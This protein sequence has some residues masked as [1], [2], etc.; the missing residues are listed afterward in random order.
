MKTTMYMLLTLLPL[1]ILSNYFFLIHLNLG[2]MGASYHLLAMGF[3]ISSVYTLYLIFG[4]PFVRN[5]WCGWSRQAWRGWGEFL[6]LGQFW[7]T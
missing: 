2:T 1:G 4:T 6:R 5:H 7:D 3:L